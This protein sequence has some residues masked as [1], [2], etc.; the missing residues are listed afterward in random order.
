VS[1]VIVL[2]LHCRDLWRRLYAFNSTFLGISNWRLVGIVFSE[3]IG[4]KDQDSL[5]NAL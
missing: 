2:V 3:E 4:P 1:L 5:E